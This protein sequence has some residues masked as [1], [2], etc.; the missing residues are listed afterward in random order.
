[1]K[2]YLSFVATNVG[3]ESMYLQIV[4]TAK[5]RMYKRINDCEQ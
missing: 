3:N 5:P 1:L 2:P 4:D